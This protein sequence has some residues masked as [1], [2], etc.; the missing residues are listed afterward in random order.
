MQVHAVTGTPGLPWTHVDC[1]ES[2]VI[3]GWP[4]SSLSVVVSKALRA[5]DK[6]TWA[7]KEVNILIIPATKG[8]VIWVG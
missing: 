4:L 1:R 5:G 2:W 7:C 3:S 6:G 8:F